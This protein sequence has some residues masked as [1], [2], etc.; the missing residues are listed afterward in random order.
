MKPTD[1]IDFMCKYLKAES[2]APA[3]QEA[4]PFALKPSVGTWRPAWGLDRLPPR[5]QKLV[6]APTAPAQ[7][8]FALR[9]SVGTW[10]MANP[11]QARSGASS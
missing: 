11:K 9:P 5:Y 7:E 4:P 1:P 2:E 10:L 3:A 8:A 6:K